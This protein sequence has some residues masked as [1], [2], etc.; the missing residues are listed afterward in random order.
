MAFVELQVLSFI[1]SE[2]KKLISNGIK[3]LPFTGEHNYNL[4]M[5]VIIT[6]LLFSVVFPALGGNSENV[7]KQKKQRS[8]PNPVEKKTLFI[9]LFNGM[10]TVPDT[11]WQLCG[12][13][14]NAWSQ[15]FK[16][17][18]MYENV[19][20]ED[21][22]FK[23]KVCKN[24]DTYKNGGVRTRMV[25]SCNSLLEVKVRLTKLIRGGFPAIWQMP[26]DGAPCPRG[27]EIDLMEWVQ[28]TPGQIYQTVH[29]F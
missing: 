14:N 21:G 27:G 15:H 3:T 11:T 16:D 5:K 29:T 8:E 17:V 18:N 13:A 4:R 25:F 10:A 24:G 23:L 19:K 22:Y 7:Q 1:L 28:G 2:L 12:Y 26:V 9:D 20:I 6:I